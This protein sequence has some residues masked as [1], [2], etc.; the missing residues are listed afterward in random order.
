MSAV[1]GP[2]LVSMLEA[3]TDLG[4][5]TVSLLLEAE[6]KKTYRVPLAASCIPMVI[7]ALVAELGKIDASLPP[8]ETAGLQDVHGGIKVGVRPDGAAALI[9]TLQGVELPLTL[10]K[11]ELINLRKGID[12]AV[13][14]IDRVGQG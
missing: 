7:A 13:V 2:R 14:M 9:L 12:E 10:T 11:E 6:S 5:R 1:R 3:N 8:G 4:T